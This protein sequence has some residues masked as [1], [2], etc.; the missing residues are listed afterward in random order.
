M[1]SKTKSIIIHSIL[2]T[3]LLEGILQFNA[4]KNIFS[5]TPPLS[6]MIIYKY[7]WPAQV[8]IH[9]LLWRGW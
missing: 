2:G 1:P 6:R 3:K 7:L 8:V 5:P 9:Y 4:K